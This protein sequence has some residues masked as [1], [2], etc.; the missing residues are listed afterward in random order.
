MDGYE[1]YKTYLALKRHFEPGSTYDYVKYNGKVSGSPAS[2]ESRN[3]RVFFLKLAKHPDVLGFLVA[4]LSYNPKLWIKTLAYS[5]ECRMRYEGRQ[6][7]IESLS[8]SVITEIGR[9]DTDVFNDIFTIKDGQHPP[10]LR[11]FMSG[12]I[13]L[14]T[15]I[16]LDDLVNYSRVWKKALEYDPIVTDVLSRIEKARPFLTYDRESLRAALIKKFS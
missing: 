5:D 15:M 10:L 16:A 7:L 6:K 12:S 2:F 9:V 11:A 8:Y 14:E 1:A 13:S 4:N 3:D